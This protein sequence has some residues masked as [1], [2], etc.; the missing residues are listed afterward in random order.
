MRL[1][2]GFFGRSL[3]LCSLA[4]GS[5]S[6]GAKTG[7]RVWDS[8]TDTEPEDVFVR[9]D[10]CVAGRFT[11]VRRSAQMVFVIDR[12]GSMDQP[13][14]TAGGITRWGAMRTVFS[15]TLPMF[16]NN[17]EM[18]VM[19]YPRV[20]VDSILMYRQYCQLTSSGSIDV[21]PRLQNA[22][23]VVDS[24]FRHNPWGATP[25]AAAIVRAT[26]YL[27]SQDTRGRARYLV[28]ATDGAPNCNATLDGSTCLCLGG[29]STC[30]SPEGVLS[31]LDDQGTLN[32]ISA[33]R[34]EGV[35]TYVV[36]IDGDLERPFV[37]LLERMADMG[38]RPR[39]DRPRYYSIR[40]LDTLQS[41][42]TD[43]QRTV[44][45]CAYV[46]P[47]RPD[48]PDAIE[49]SVAGRPIRRDPSRRDGWDWT[50]R[51]YGELTFFG[52]ECDAIAARRP[53]L[54]ALVTC[55]DR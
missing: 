32:A 3:L 39:T 22:G 49:V 12:S 9:F 19:F 40:D 34:R 29:P 11:L 53:P 41:A 31:C 7:L 8:G 47:S 46:T 26:E 17:L 13:L 55:G 16:E 52:P 1:L 10:A 20:P 50:D 5:S 36:G 38:G 51:D 33:A 23:P 43:I 25:T 42:F 37:D 45:Q 48:N 2:G 15:R 18:G 14:M 27:R 35:S 4:W 21:T 28:L 6:C 30:N 54:D 24:I 44:V